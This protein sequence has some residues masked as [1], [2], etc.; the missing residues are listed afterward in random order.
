[1]DEFRLASSD[2]NLE[3][4]LSDIRGDYCK[5]QILSDHVTV[6]RE[7]WAYRDP[8]DSANLIEH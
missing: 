2:T 1:M 8:Y 3:L 4:V 6:V 5:A 7:V